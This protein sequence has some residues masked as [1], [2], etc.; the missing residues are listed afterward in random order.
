MVC[1]Q[2]D[3]NMIS[4]EIEAKDLRLNTKKTKLLVITRKQKPPAPTLSIKGEV[5]EQVPFFKYLGI[6]ISQNLSW[7]LH[8]GNTCCKAR[9]L[10]GYLYRCFRLADRAC[11]S[12][13]YRSLVLPVL[14]SYCSSV[15]DPLESTHINKLER[16]QGFAA[17]L[18]TGRRSERSEPIRKKLGWPSLV[19][20]RKVQKL[21]LCK[22]I[23]LGGSL[24][25]ATCFQHHQLVHL[26]HANSKPHCRK[27]VRTNYCKQSFFV[28]TVPPWNGIPEVIVAQEAASALKKQVKHIS[29]N[30]VCLLY[31][32]L[33]SYVISVCM[34][35]WPF[36]LPS[37]PCMESL[38][39][40]QASWYFQM[41][42][43]LNI[44]NNNNNN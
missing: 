35:V 18:V 21:C 10:L 23:L 5:V 38:I 43:A 37:L 41:H 39:I 44:K 8:M 34:C 3:L 14:L 42:L 4:D 12:Q 22:W 20:Q 24:I 6:T 32:V 25:P 19:D 13:L 17:R 30:F 9:R 29:F 1:A 31:F 40:A 2:S 28:S 7:S 16:V 26:R 11:L 33:C 15:W 36:F 27:A